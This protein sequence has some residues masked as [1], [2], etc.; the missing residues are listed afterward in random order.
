M[1]VPASSGY[2]QYS[3]NLINPLFSMD[4]LER[5]YAS[6]LYSDISTT[7]YSGELEKGGDQITFWREPR[8]RVRSTTKNEPIQHDTISS[9]PITMTIDQ[10]EEFSIKMSTIDE[11]QIQNFP[12]WKEKFLQSAGRELA[13]AIDG[14]LMTAMY[15][16][17]DVA[18][19]GA[20]AGLKSKN[21]NMGSVGAPVAITSANITQILA[22]VH[23]VLD[24]Q[25]APTAERFVTIPPAGIT[26]L[27]NSDLRAAYLTGLSWSPITNGKLPDEVMGFMIMRSNLIPQA[28]DAGV[29]LLAYHVV[30]GVKMATAFA[31]QIE[32]TR[33]IEDKEEWSTFYQGLTVYGFKVLYPDAL[34]HLYCTFS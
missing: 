21:I 2:P 5:F 29:S 3:G 4:L 9:E 14:P 12:L 10:A 18:N 25:N 6:T 33:V 17:V 8:V 19:Q 31:A 30:A 27:R 24:E 7:E 34:V 28:I 23:Q 16:S 15:T 26:A 32:K 13:I 20:T 22:Q 11:V 1:A